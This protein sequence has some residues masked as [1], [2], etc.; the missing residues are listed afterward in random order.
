MHHLEGVLCVLPSSR[1]GLRETTD[2]VTPA[3]SAA[4]RTVDANPFSDRGDLQLDDNLASSI[5]HPSS[6]YHTVKSSLIR[7]SLINVRIPLLAVQSSLRMYF[8]A[9]PYEEF[10]PSHS[11][12]ERRSY[13]YRSKS[14]FK[15]QFRT[16][17]S[18]N[19]TFVT[20]YFRKR[21]YPAAL[22]CM[23]LLVIAT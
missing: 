20:K 2:F 6:N 14:H 17:F 21:Y 13:G 9:Q 11:G 18:P 15:S 3:T 8:D 7:C 22:T 4:P 23:V 10:D 16:R 5:F 19:C 12:V 1:K